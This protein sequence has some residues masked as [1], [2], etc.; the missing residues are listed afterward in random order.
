M[1]GGKIQQKSEDS[2]EQEPESSK[3]RDKTPSNNE[4]SAFPS[5]F[6]S[7]FDS[8]LKRIFYDDDGEEEKQTIKETSD[9]PTEK[10]KKGSKTAEKARK[11]QIKKQKRTTKMQI[12]EVYKEDE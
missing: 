7:Y 9:D 5:V 1:R 8:S 4:K 12:N 2:E 10:K 11:P 6:N 3:S